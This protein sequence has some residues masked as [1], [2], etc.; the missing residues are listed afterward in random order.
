MI[1]IR[2]VA[3][4]L[5]LTQ[6]YRIEYHVCRLFVVLSEFTEA[7]V[8]PTGFPGIITRLVPGRTDNGG[9]TPTDDDAIHL[10]C[11]MLMNTGRET[12]QS[13][14]FLNGAVETLL[15]GEVCTRISSHS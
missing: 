9:P 13:R 12:L 7:L 14:E 10:G 8:A 15:L 6:L 2:T 11:V 3:T 5:Q 1:M 4:P